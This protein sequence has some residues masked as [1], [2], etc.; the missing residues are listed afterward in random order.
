MKEITKISRVVW[1]DHV[2]KTM[3]EICKT[4]YP[5]ENWDAQKYG[6]VR[7]TTI[8]YERGTR[9]TFYQTKTISYDIC[10]K[11]FEVVLMPFLATFGAEPTI[12]EEDG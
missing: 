8:S 4:R 5:G 6:D 12:T 11:C 1:T 3:C 7:R 2:E 10:P 9:W